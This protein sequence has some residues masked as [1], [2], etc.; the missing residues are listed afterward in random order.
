MAE[1]THRFIQT[2]RI[3]MHIAEQG[4]GPLVILCHGFPE[5][6]Y[7]WR[8]QLLALSE[9]GYHVVAPDQRGYGQTDR[10]EPM[11]AY[12]ILEL[13][14]DIVGLVDA[15]NQEQAI[16]VGHDWGAVVAWYCSLLRPDIF[17][18]TVLLSVPYI[19]RAWADIRPTDAMKQMVGEKQFYQLY[20]QEPG[21]AEAELDEDVRKAITMFL[22]SASG[23]PPPE[24]RWRYLFSKSEKLLD[25]GALPE[26]LPAW[27]TEQDIDFFTSEF[28][29]TGF[30]GGLNW[31]RNF[32]RNWELT[33]FLSGA[34]L[35]QPALFVAGELDPV[36][37]MSRN[38]FD[39]MEQTVP[40]LK[41]KVL[42][43]GAG[44]WIQQ[45]RPTEVN[46]LLTEFL[47]GLN[48]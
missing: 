11:E 12:N 46:Q 25:T 23:N 40:N 24:K 5:S 36:I 38:A 26:T 42:L 10:P 32:D 8:H 30:R 13:T 33:T 15:L 20:F 9:A 3:K 19:P 28:E 18:T 47:T 43:S 6:W 21:L 48:G 17:T 31:Y 41:Q 27:L 44:H 4:E 37:A 1:I 7:S 2:N 34:K 22:Y 16:I 29:R 14:A 45:E 35:R 39:A